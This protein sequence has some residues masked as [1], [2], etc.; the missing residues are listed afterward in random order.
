MEIIQQPQYPILQRQPDA[1]DDPKDAEFLATQYSMASGNMNPDAV[2]QVTDML[3]RGQ[4]DVLRESIAARRNAEIPQERA[5]VLQDALVQGDVDKAYQVATTSP[6]NVPPNVVVEQAVAEEGVTHRMLTEDIRSK[7]D[8]SDQEL[9]DAERLLIIGNFFTEMKK[10]L[11]T[12]SNPEYVGDPK[13]AMAKAGASFDALFSGMENVSIPSVWLALKGIQAGEFLSAAGEVA[14]I[15]SPDFY[16]DFLAT[17]VNTPTAGAKSKGELG[18]FMLTGDAG[19]E[20]QKKLVTLPPEELATFLEESKDYLKEAVAENPL[21]GF[22]IAWD[23]TYATSILNPTETEAQF[24]LWKKVEQIPVPMTD[25]QGNQ[26]LDENGQPQYMMV[27]N[28]LNENYIQGGD[29]P[30][31]KFLGAMDAVL[32]K[33]SV[34]SL[35]DSPIMDATLMV[36]LTKGALSS[37]S[38]LRTIVN[39]MGRGAAAPYVLSQAA[40]GTGTTADVYHHITTMVAP[41][42]YVDPALAAEIGHIQ[43]TAKEMLQNVSIAPRVNLTPQQVS[44]SSL[45]LRNQDV[46]FNREFMFSTHEV[47]E[48]NTF[49]TSFYGNGRGSSFIS[50]QAAQTWA[51]QK[52]IKDFRIDQPIAGQFY[53]AVRSPLSDADFYPGSLHLANGADYFRTLLGLGEYIWTP[54]TTSSRELGAAATSAPLLNGIYSEIGRYVSSNMKGLSRKEVNRLAEVIDA[55]KNAPAPN[56]PGYQGKWFSEREFEQ[57]YYNKFGEMPSYKEKKSYFVFKEASNLNFALMNKKQF[58]QAAALAV[59]AFRSTNPSATSEFLGKMVDASQIRGEFLVKLPT[60][61][62][63]SDP[64]VLRTALQQPDVVAIRVYGDMKIGNDNVTHILGIKGEFKDIGLPKQILHYAEGGSRMYLNPFFL[65]GR[66]KNRV[67]TLGVFSSKKEGLAHKAK[68]DRG[69]ATYKQFLADMRSATR[70]GVI[71]AAAER[72][73]RAQYDPVLAAI[74]S[75]FSTSSFDAQIKN[76]YLDA[77]ADYHV[78][79][80]RQP[81]PGQAGRDDF[82]EVET[83]FK[84]ENGRLYYSQRGAMLFEDGGNNPATL[85]NPFD[86]LTQQMSHAIRSAGFSDFAIKQMQSWATKYQPYMTDQSKA[87]GVLDQIFLEGKFPDT[88][89]NGMTKRQMWLAEAERSH[90]K[91]L[92]GH[93]DA[94][95]AWIDKNRLLLAE[96]TAAYFGDKDW[97]QGKKYL[98]SLRTGRI[99]QG[100]VIGTLRGIAYDL[101]MGLFNAGH[102]VLQAAGST[103]AIGMHPLYGAVSVLETTLMWPLLMFRDS[104]NAVDTVDKAAAALGYMP[105][106]EFKKAMDLYQKT[107][108]HNI[109]HTD[110]QLDTLAKIDGIGGGALWNKLRSA[111]RVPVYEGERFARITTFNIA[112][113][114]ADEEVLAGRLVRD[115]AEYVDFIRGKTGALTLNMLSGMEAAWSKNPITSLAMQMLQYPIKATEVYLGLNRQLTTEEKVMFAIT[116]P[117]L[118]GA[119]GFPGGPQLLEAYIEKYRPDMPREEKKRLMFGGVDM[120]LRNVVGLD[121]AYAQRLGFGDFWAGFA[122]KLT[123]QGVA[124]FLG[125]IV[126][127]EAKQ[128]LEQGSIMLQI[129]LAADSAADTERLGWENITPAVMSEIGSMASGFSNYRRAHILNQY[130]MLLNSKGTAVVEY[131]SNYNA[132]AVALGIPSSEEAFNNLG[133]Q[134]SVSKEAD[135]KEAVKQFAKYSIDSVKYGQRMLENPND[136]EAEQMYRL[137]NLQKAIVLKS[138]EDPDDVNEIIGK[139]N[140]FIENDQ[141][142]L[143]AAKQIKVNIKMAVE[144]AMEQQ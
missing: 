94:V 112:R 55:G 128:G 118:W 54:A 133:I 67:F 76:G 143:N 36:G 99:A 57:Q 80:D 95:S 81:F 50:E 4:A 25:D 59:T 74:D 90:I 84:Q 134:S 20:F 87:L 132:F 141:K 34:Q 17:F 27:P 101:S 63:T 92:L 89:V 41:N 113:R 28:P 104:K 98:T 30:T 144:Q 24:N 109:R 6:H 40:K 37:I 103:A 44:Q 32:S 115:S 64:N 73:I 52:G 21:R 15:F 9:Q 127:N 136:K 10:D 47:D 56:Q 66:D 79:Y 13:A 19:R 117:M 77:N 130:G 29:R 46:L 78:L 11:A 86:T 137:S 33:A 2:A 93:P 71:S 1:Y 48:G 45:N 5:S 68:I 65:K 121:A 69:L 100:D 3:Q 83:A 82:N 31:D 16:K 8:F 18:K 97:M 91:R 116:Q 70:G 106:G 102:L 39:V 85:I 58:D 96:R 88:L 14:A 139:A 61:G 26:I 38:R 129:M 12:Y 23:I 114:I 110:T 142:T 123:Q 140:F 131:N 51:S 122:N 119:Y 126:Y 138:F 42:S 53:V 135:K 120:F 22:S 105:R 43:T 72:R 107:G 125:G 108:L 75:R 35:V 62:V 124:A 111:G 7:E 60:G 49:I